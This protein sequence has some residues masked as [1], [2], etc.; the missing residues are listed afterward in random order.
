MN[1]GQSERGSESEVSKQL[2]S[3][4]EQY[5]RPSAICDFTT[6]PEIRE[7]A[8]EETRGLKSRR[9]KAWKV[10][11]WVR[12]SIP[13]ALDEWEVKASETLRK[14]YGMCM[15]KTNLAVAQLRSIGIPARY[16]FLLIKRNEWFESIVIQGDSELAQ[17]YKYVPQHIQHVVCQFYVGR[18]WE[19]FDPAR[20]SLLERGFQVLGIPQERVIVAELAILSSPDE[21]VFRRSRHVVNNREEFFRKTNQQ[22]EKIR[23]YVN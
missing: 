7:K 21:F 8:L 15:N 5:L 23:S 17:M 3:S 6:H 19:E 16:R 10:L 1:R 11:T 12:D 13:Y 20:D 4:L 22:I 2:M 18:R 9:E 14:G